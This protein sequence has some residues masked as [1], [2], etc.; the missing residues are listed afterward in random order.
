MTDPREHS[1]PAAAL[2]GG[3]PVITVSNAG[4]HELN[5]RPNLPTYL[6]Q[7]WQRRHFIRAEAKAKAFQTT[8]DLRLGKAWLLLNPL[9]ESAM[10]GVI[11]GLLMHTS[12]GIDN[13]IGFVVLG[14]TFF[15]VFT[16]QM[17]A[18]VE[19]V[20]KQQ[21]LTRSYNFP[22]ASIVF[23]ASLRLL[24]DTALP[25]LVA[26]VF[27]LVMQGFKNVSATV[28]LVP[29]LFLMAHMMSTGLNFIA[30]RATA[31]IP[32][33]RIVFELGSRAWFFTSGVF[34]SVKNMNVEPWVLQVVEL[35]P[36]Y[37][38]LNLLRTVV[39]EGRVGSAQE[40]TYIAAWTVGL[41]VVGLVA[42][43]QAEERY[44]R[45]R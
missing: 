2:D 16:K 36:A 41:F 7:L 44:V 3:R 34:F 42:F 10:Y 14:I 27:A 8:R 11:F 33:L 43:W 26:V 39:M 20:K 6:A 13:F 15:Q 31:F 45:V 37:H 17:N 5:V 38:F 9:I 29:V 30:A 40:W 12:R 28:L 18:G 21:N 19:L 22:R 32:D 35:N 23:S 24:Y 1:Q 25:M 4:L